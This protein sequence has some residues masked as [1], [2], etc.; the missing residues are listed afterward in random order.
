MGK[1]NKGGN[2]GG[3]RKG[4]SSPKP[5]PKPSRSPSPK[6]SPKP[7]RSPSRNPSPSP[8]RNP[9]PSP[10]PARQQA[11]AVAQMSVKDRR[12]GAKAAGVT[13]KDFKQGNTGSKAV[14][15]KTAQVNKNTGGGNTGGGNTGGGSSINYNPAARGGA[16]FGNED[17]N[18]LKSQGHNDQQ[19]NSYLGTL[20]NSQVSNKY[21]A[22]GGFTPNPT[23]TSTGGGI[24]YSDKYDTSSPNFHSSYKSLM[25][26]YD[27]AS[28]GGAAFG[29]EDYDYLRSQGHTESSINSYLGE[30]DTSQVSNKYK[31]RGGHTPNASINS[32]RDSSDGLYQDRYSVGKG[33]E[34]DKGDM[35]LSQGALG[36]IN[37]YFN[38]SGNTQEDVVNSWNAND[39]ERSYT[40]WKDTGNSEVGK[41]HGGYAG[42]VL[43]MI[44]QNNFKVTDEQY[45]RLVNDAKNHNWN[46]QM[47][48]DGTQAGRSHADFDASGMYDAR[49]GGTMESQGN[50]N[51]VTGAKYADWTNSEYY[52]GASV[53]ARNNRRQ[54]VN[55]SMDAAAFQ[56]SLHGGNADVSHMHREMEQYKPAGF[57]YDPWSGATNQQTM[58]DNNFQNF[59][60]QESDFEAPTQAA[61]NFDMPNVQ[62]SMG[63]QYQGWQEQMGNATQSPYTSRS[64]SSNMNF[65]F[66]P[67]KFQQGQ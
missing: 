42:D 22:Q 26:N 45:N 20:N 67:Y 59:G 64:K 23:N 4:G 5:S 29:N 44:D 17:Y 58:G 47:S 36:N 24:D 51:D 48:S 1:K 35:Y 9:S 30:L 49:L 18:H 11:K 61:S 63:P 13:L 62:Q 2:K 54:Q 16:A 60:S 32:G 6:P 53:D 19:I 15:R 10:A 7:S 56:K 46:S 28:R 3:G 65:N 12:A 52:S 33:G 50:M 55:D 14:A 39:F 41:G 66:N 57:Q 31:T 43:K 34:D 38:I 25:G 37:S 21:K 27:P 40:S 8:S